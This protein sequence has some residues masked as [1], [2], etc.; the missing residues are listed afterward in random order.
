MMPANRSLKLL[1]QADV[2][3]L[4]ADLFRRPSRDL[5]ER[6]HAALCSLEALLLACAFDDDRGLLIELRQA[7]LAGG[8]AEPSPLSDE[9][10]RLFDGT[11][12]CPPNETAFVRRDK[13]AV[14][15]DVCGFYRAFGF[16]PRSDTGEKPD[17]L[18]TQ[19]EFCAMLLVMLHGA[20]TPEQHD[21]VRKALVEF[22]D[23]HLGEWL[24]TF[25]ARLGSVTDLNFYRA[26]ALALPAAWAALAAAHGLRIEPVSSAAPEPEPDEPYECGLAPAP[27]DPI[28]L[29]IRRRAEPALL[30]G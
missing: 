9:Y 30:R 23:C 19:L 27:T 26:L 13:G 20:Q 21:V 18:V 3:L 22:A 10:H 14:I 1:A 11:M 17:H 24:A 6:C 29:N 25:A 4:L 2:L 28:P 16:T 5:A 8:V 7:L 12:L 15:S